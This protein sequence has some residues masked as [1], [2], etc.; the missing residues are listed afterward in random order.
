MF[1]LHQNRILRCY[2]CRA[3]SDPRHVVP[4]RRKRAK[5]RGDFQE[6]VSEVRWSKVGPA[7][8]NRQTRDSE[9]EAKTSRRV[10]RSQYDRTPNPAR[11][12]LPARC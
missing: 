2:R 9:K 11:Q 7:V 8:L 5:G 4:L 6:L 1:G 12:P 10:H 3:G